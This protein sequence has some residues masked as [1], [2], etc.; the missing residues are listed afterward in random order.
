MGG[1]EGVKSITVYT[2][3]KL[4]CSIYYKE[5]L[6]HLRPLYMSVCELGRQAQTTWHPEGA[7]SPRPLS[8][9]PLSVF[10]FLFL[11]LILLSHRLGMER[12][13]N[14]ERKFKSEVERNEWPWKF[15]NVFTRS[16]YHLITCL[17]LCPLCLWL[18]VVPFRR[19]SLIRPRI[20]K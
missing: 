2:V 18:S 15:E 13:N 10:F 5:G 1:E 6:L 14:R 17:Q 3:I 19:N 12:Q 8:L 9:C 7:F 20:R 4:A 11:A 16:D